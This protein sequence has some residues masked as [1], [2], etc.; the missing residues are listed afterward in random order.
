MK[1]KNKKKKIKQITSNQMIKKKA[2]KS[3]PKI[4]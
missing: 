2:I 3:I 1:K 4:Y